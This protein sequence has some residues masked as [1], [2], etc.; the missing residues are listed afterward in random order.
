MGIV[1]RKETRDTRKTTLYT[2]HDGRAGETVYCVN[3][4]FMWRGKRGFKISS[5]N[6][7]VLKTPA[8]TFTRS[9]LWNSA[10]EKNWKKNSTFEI[11]EEEKKIIPLGKMIDGRKFEYSKAGLDYLE[12]M[13]RKYQWR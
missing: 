6:N 5:L 8:Q 3:I 11:L 12:A 1:E 13:T 7:S 9:S 2:K 4:D 10:A